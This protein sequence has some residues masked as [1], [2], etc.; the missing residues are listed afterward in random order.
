VPVQNSTIADIF[1]NIA[2]LLEIEG[3]N[4]FRVRAY[5][6]AARTIEGY[7]R[8]LEEMIKADE[9]IDEIPGVGDDLSKKIREI[10]ETGNLSFYETLRARTPQ[11]LIKLLDISGLGPK[12]VQQIYRELDITNLEALSA[13]YV[14][15]RWA[16]PFW[17]CFQPFISRFLPIS[18]HLLIQGLKDGWWSSWAVS[19]L[20]LSVKC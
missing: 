10:V 7:P 2:D 8:R 5:R 12:R 3:A 18:C 9:P 1:Y 6:E 19:H 15:S 13:A 20:C 11:S 17:C 16:Y 14:W 4:T